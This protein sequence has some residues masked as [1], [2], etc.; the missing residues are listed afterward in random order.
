MRVLV[1]ESAASGMPF[2]D[3][4][5][6]LVGRPVAVVSEQEV[7]KGTDV[8]WDVDLVVFGRRVWSEDALAVVTTLR[9]SA[10]PAPLL[11]VSGPCSVES[12]VAALGRGV[13][14]FLHIPFAV[15]EF[16]ARAKALVRRGARLRH[17]PL[18]L[19]PLQRVALLDDR[20]LSLTA[21]EFDIL[22]GLARRAGE[23]VTYP[24]LMRVAERAEIS[25]QSNWLN[26]HINRIRQKLG[27]HARVLETVRGEGYRLRSREP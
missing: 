26:V 2:I 27:R 1:L 3:E 22:L 23:V 24:E 7:A 12:R 14:E 21:K 16:V 25:R 13:D 20:P 10:L 8:P 4:L 17:G 9:D 6:S 19:D 11:I 18:L 15:E 5:I